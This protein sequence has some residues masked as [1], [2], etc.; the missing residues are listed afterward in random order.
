MGSER[1]NQRRV[2]LHDLC[3]RAPSREDVHRCAMVLKEMAMLRVARS[4][5]GT[6]RVS[7]IKAD[8]QTLRLPLRFDL[9]YM[10]GHAFQALLTD[11]DA[12]AVLRTVRDHLTKDG[13]LCL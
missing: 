3:L 12:I 5:Q 7:W 1:F 9:I 10:T 6:E 13:R 4:R 11:D 2:G 8:G